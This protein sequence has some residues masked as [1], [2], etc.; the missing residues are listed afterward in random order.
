MF[1]DSARPRG[2]VLFGNGKRRLLT[3]LLAC[4]CPDW[5]RHLLPV[6]TAVAYRGQRHGVHLWEGQVADVT[7]FEVPALAWV[8]LCDLPPQRAAWTADAFSM[9]TAFDL[10]QDD[11]QGSMCTLPSTDTAVHTDLTRMLAAQVKT[12]VSLSNVVEQVHKVQASETGRWR[13]F[14][15]AP[16]HTVCHL[17]EGAKKARICV[18]TGCRGAVMMEAHGASV[19]VGHPGI[20]RTLA[21]VADSY[22]WPTMAADVEAFV[23]SCRVL[24]H[25]CALEWRRLVLCP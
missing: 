17:V 2:R 1:W 14:Y 22:Y 9:L 18:P 12:D 23:R 20:S 11:Q 6:P 19:L 8:E 10:F 7:A 3:A 21:S 25:I 5:A 16:N 15:I 24:A 4:C 13:G